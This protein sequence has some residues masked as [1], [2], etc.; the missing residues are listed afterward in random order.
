MTATNMKGKNL[1]DLN[2]FTVVNRIEKLIKN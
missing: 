1:S 2:F